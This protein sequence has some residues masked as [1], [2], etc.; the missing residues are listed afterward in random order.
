[1]VSFNS[2]LLR[3]KFTI[4][5]P[6]DGSSE[7]GAPVLALSNRMVVELVSKSGQ[8]KERFI[9]RTHNMHSCVRIAARLIRTYHTTGPILVRGKDFEWEAIWDQIVN[10]YEYEYNPQRWASIYNNG[11]VLFEA[12]E[13]HPFLDVIEKCDALNKGEYEKAIPVAES[14]FKQL[15]REVTIEYDANVALVTDMDDKQARCGVILRGPSRTT[16]FNFAVFPKKE[17]VL[18]IPQI[19]TSSA[20]FLEG[21]QL[22]FMIGMNNEKIRLG[23]IERFSHE[24]KQ[25]REA[26]R[27]LSRLNA[28][29]ANLESACD[30][31]YR[32]E[33][34]EFPHIVM[35]A[36][37]LAE[38][39]LKA[40]PPK[41][42][43]D[44]PAE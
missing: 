35:D 16:T 19:L 3:E 1:M 39:I 2:S 11:K 27:R 21:I 20:A 17:P 14:A 43:E 33:R 31:R 8:N 18:N 7:T 10:E 40:P 26:R 13:R 38:K 28:E 22:A 34:P 6:L 9:I 36:E 25:T 41:P 29:I 24:E 5:D 15:G 32:P 23:I 42:K 44:K 4:H 37:K 30:V 12:G